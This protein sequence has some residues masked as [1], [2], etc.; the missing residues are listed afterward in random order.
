MHDPGAIFV[1]ERYMDLGYESVFRREI[2]GV[3]RFDL[4]IKSS[5]DVNFIKNVEVKR[6][7]SD[8]A[9][10]IA[11]NIKNAGSQIKD[12]DTIALVLP[13]HKQNSQSVSLAKEAFEEAARKGWIKGPVE[14]WFSDKTMINLN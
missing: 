6:C 1:A 9:S 14:V 10:Q 8:N 5:D 11:K 7:T 13:N 4:T 2:D 12:G 3:K